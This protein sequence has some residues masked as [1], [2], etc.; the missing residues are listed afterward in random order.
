[1]SLPRTQETSRRCIHDV[2]VWWGH[3]CG[4]CMDE[5]GVFVWVDDSTATTAIVISDGV[6]RDELDPEGGAG[7]DWRVAHIEVRRG[8]EVL[9]T[10]QV[11]PHDIVVFPGTCGNI[12]IIRR[13]PGTGRQVATEHSVGIY[14]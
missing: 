11:T 14:E 8:G 6:D 10:L 4:I 13:P 5:Y 9:A 12:G 7:L 3:E 2:D 1:M